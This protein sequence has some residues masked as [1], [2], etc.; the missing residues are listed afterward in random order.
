MTSGS[1]SLPHPDARSSAGHWLAHLLATLAA[2]LL[3]GGAWAQD[4]VGVDASV[5]VAVENA[6]S[7]G[8]PG[9]L[10]FSRTI[11]DPS[12][13]V[14]INF[15]VSYTATLEGLASPSF[16]FTSDAATQTNSNSATSIA[17]AITIP[18]GQKSATVSVTALENGI[19]LTQD[20]RKVLITITAGSYSILANQSA[21]IQL[22]E[23]DLTAT[24]LVTNP[25]ATRAPIP[26]IPADP[27]FNR[28]GLMSMPF[29]PIGYPGAL[30]V[31]VVPSGTATFDTDYTCFFRIG[32][33]AF[34]VGL[35]Y[36]VTAYLVGE[37]VIQV[38]PN[39]LT[40][41]G[42]NDTFA[43][44]DDPNTTYTITA[45]GPGTITV[46]PALV[47]NHTFG[48]SL[49]FG[50]SGTYG[51][52]SLVDTAAV[53]NTVIKIENGTAPFA[54][55]DVLQFGN[56]TT[57]YEVTSVISN[58]AGH[59]SAVGTNEEII[60][61][62]YWNSSTTNSAPNSL[63]VTIN[64]TTS[65]N[66][67][68]TPGFQ[69]VLTNGVSQDI[70]V[71]P[72][73]QRMQFATNPSDVLPSPGT[74]AVTA[75]LTALGSVNY[76]M[77]NPTTGSVTIADATNTLDITSL[78]DGTFPNGALS[79]TSGAFLITCTGPGFDRDI[80]VPFTVNSTMTLGT[81]YSITNCSPGSPVSGYVTLPA[82]QTSA[83]VVVDSGPTALAVGTPL[84]MVLGNSADYQARHQPALDHQPHRHHQHAPQLRR[85]HRDRDRPGRQRHRSRGHQPVRAAADLRVAARRDDRRYHHR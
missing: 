17:A 58:A 1:I 29:T 72:G 84:T 77:L 9:V 12:S 2:A 42:V 68:L 4:F 50:V 10:T 7:T 59:Y 73:A 64:V 16:N 5:P 44:S 82:G 46:S 78:N 23:A 70:L 80:A 8:A 3:G 36:D 45:V 55:G 30:V 40:P 71:P 24:M 48:A 65:V 61:N 13:A 66:A 56:D 60:V 79:G 57:Y 35:G 15:T 74:G 18:A 11:A 63:D 52:I 25:S 38:N 85:G 27:N 6:S 47:E 83:E 34:D 33:S 32:P 69:L 37:N 43:F 41:P 28:R 20:N 51:V 31:N 75:T 53:S 54:V 81:N 21:I 49:Q 62:P 76:T 19:V 39:V 22:S 67:S 26:G 14:T